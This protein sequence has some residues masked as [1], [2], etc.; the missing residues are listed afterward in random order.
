MS[1]QRGFTLIEVMIIV[2]IAGA[3]M[4]LA[5]PKMNQAIVSANVNGAR[6]AVAAT[7][8]R[9]R[10]VAVETGRPT[11]L[12]FAGTVMHVTA[13]PRIVPAAGSTRDTVGTVQNLGQ[14]FGVSVVLSSDDLGFDPRGF[15][16]NTGTTTV[17][18]FKN[19]Y[20]KPLIISPFGRLRP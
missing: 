2:V 15:G 13:E 11:R 8:A 5:F 18:V 7:F 6:S 16:T 20:S 19:G 10:A 17:T 1:E 9:A 14:Q 4:L 3:L 12:R